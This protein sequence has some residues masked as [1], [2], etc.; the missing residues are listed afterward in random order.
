[1]FDDL[2]FVLGR[3]PSKYSHFVDDLWFEDE[4][5]DEGVLDGKYGCLICSANVWVEVFDD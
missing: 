5:F 2:Y 4:V 1:M 3:H